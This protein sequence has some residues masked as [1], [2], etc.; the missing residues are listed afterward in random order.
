M[1]AGDVLG[2]SKRCPLRKPCFT[3]M[4]VSIKHF[5]LFFTDLHLTLVPF[6]RPIGYQTMKI[7]AGVFRAGWPTVNDSPVG[8]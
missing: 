6:H 3:V 2:A 4:I 7:A 5:E 1:A 8:A